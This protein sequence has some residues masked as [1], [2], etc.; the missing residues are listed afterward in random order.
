MAQI[1][2]QHTRYAT[3]GAMND[4]RGASAQLAL[5]GLCVAVFTIA[6]AALISSQLAL[7]SVLDSA[8]AERAADQIATS[9]FTAEVIEQTVVRAVSPVAGDEVATQLAV[10]ASADPR[11]TDA[12]S[13]SLMFTHRQIVE[14]DVIAADGNALIRNEIASSVLDSAAA[15]GF[16]P[17][18][19]GID[20]DSATALP[21]DA[22]AEQEGLASLLPTDLP[23]LELRPVAETTRV[24]AAI[25]TVIFG[26]M[27]VLV[28]P[29]SA[30]GLRRLG[31]VA[32]TVCGIWLVSMLLAGW[33]I[34]LVANTLFGEMLHTVWS[35]AAGSMMLL[36]GAGAVLGLGVAIGGSAVQGWSNERRRGAR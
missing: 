30:H 26:L 10:A 4:R 22:V 36:V 27:A 1:G 7:M 17:A 18:S 5:A 8:R 32:V 23:A 21:L 24:I 15:A 28:H 11:V 3:M 13:S 20:V 12:V 19:F 6:L 29:R 16:D 33:I 14:G 2:E 9:R 31:I 34:G 35:D 25:V